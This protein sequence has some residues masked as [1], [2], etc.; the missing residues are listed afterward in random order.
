MS[1]LGTLP[2]SLQKTEQLG[3]GQGLWAPGLRRA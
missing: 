1:L 2:W 3:E